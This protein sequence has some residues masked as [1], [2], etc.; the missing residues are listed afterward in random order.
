MKMGAAQALSAKAN[1]LAFENGL[2]RVGRGALFAPPYSHTVGR[3]RSVLAAGCCSRGI[4]GLPAPAR[5]RSST[6][7]YRSF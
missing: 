2:C 4:S 5:R 3:S 1:L 7:M 6:T